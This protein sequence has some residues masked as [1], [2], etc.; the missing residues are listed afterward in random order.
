[1]LRS[2]WLALVMLAAC[3]HA[4]SAS[5]DRTATQAASTA[6][7][8][9]RSIVDAGAARACTLSYACGLSHPGL[10]TS[11][12]TTSVDFATCE[13]TRSS[14]SG[15]FEEPNPLLGPSG[16]SD[17]STSKSSTTRLAHADCDRLV[18]LTASI[19][20]DDLGKAQESAQVDTTACTLSLM[21]ASDPSRWA[22][23]VQRQSLTGGGAVVNLL[24]AL[25]AAH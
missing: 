10:G 23:Q 2:P 8:A 9:R 11:S 21:C 5:V 16:V 19:T 6:P 12:N 7:S 15:P 24:H 14:F 20:Q 4:K 17:A 13:M 22:F 3:D 25:L 18:E 1:M